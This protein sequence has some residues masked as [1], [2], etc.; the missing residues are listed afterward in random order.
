LRFARNGDFLFRL[1]NG[2]VSIDQLRRAAE[3]LINQVGHWTPERWAGRSEPMHVLIQRFA[4]RAA[5]LAG[6][7]RRKVPRLPDFALPDQLRVVV[8]ELI[9]ADPTPATVTEAT[10]EIATLRH[11]LMGRPAS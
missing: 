6:G 11:D 9:A 5:D 1:H 10:L 3:L 7:P 2:R 8:S 4:D